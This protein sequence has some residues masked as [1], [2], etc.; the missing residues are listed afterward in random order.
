[1]VEAE[2][3]FNFLRVQ[4]LFA[5]F[6]D[7]QPGAALLLLRLALAGVLVCDGS[8]FW[9]GAP[10]PWITVICGGVGVFL[11]IG[12][13]TPVVA[14]TGAVAGGLALFV[15]KC[16]DP[17]SASFVLIVMAA[18]GMLG[19]GAYSVDARIYGRRE[20]VVPLRHEQ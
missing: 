6:P 10:A 8:G 19:A 1:L 18:L 15:C 20:V 4:R 17:I 12:L 14:I 7:G 11:A 16:S 3:I 9:Q 13:F 5:T 2:I